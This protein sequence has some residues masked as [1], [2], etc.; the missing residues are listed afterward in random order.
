[1]QVKLDALENRLKEPI[2]KTGQHNGLL[3]VV[4]PGSCWLVKP[5]HNAKRAEWWELTDQFLRQRG[6]RSMPESFIWQNNWLVIR[7]IPGRTANY[8]DIQDLQRCVTLL[9]HFHLASRQVYK[10]VFFDA[11]STLDERLIRRFE[12]YERVCD[13]LTHFPQ[14]A[15]A[16]KVYRRLGDQALS[17]I[18][19]TTL[20]SITQ[21][22]IEQGAV[23]HRDLASHN[24]MIDWEERPWLIDFETA[25]LDAQLGDLW[26]LASRALVEWHWNP[27]IYETI[28]RTY[29]VIRPLSRKERVMLSQLFMFPNDFYREVIG[30][31]KQKKGFSA[32]KVIPYLH[33]IIHDQK[34]WLAFLRWLGV[35]W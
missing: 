23:A 22:D 18:D 8:N 26:Q 25:G 32:Q 27:H 4:T 11:K 14:L 31:F 9:A 1:M 34:E 10:P 5:I 7:Y 17:K 28:L 13:Q 2:I 35:A 24:I 15:V 33:M 21:F 20:K 29:E 3:L 16:S 19:E 30:L 6:F 12:Q